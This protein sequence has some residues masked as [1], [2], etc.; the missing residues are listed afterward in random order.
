MV[1]FRRGGSKYCESP[2][3]STVLRKTISYF[4]CATAT[5]ILG[6]LKGFSKG[7]LTWFRSFQT[8][9]EWYALTSDGWRSDAKQHYCTV[10]MHFFVPGTWTLVALV[11][12]TG[13]CGG[14]DHQIAQ[15]LLGVL[16]QYELV[17]ANM[18]CVT[19]DNANAEI[20]GARLA[21]MFR[22]AC[23]CHLLNLS[24]I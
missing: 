24:I 1:C 19:T 7:F 21:G 16:G 6:R 9:V 12:S 18:V 13:L 2:G 5:T 15:F 23:G 4:S 3:L 8:S 14:K 22:V 17:L 10:T 20:A 11:L